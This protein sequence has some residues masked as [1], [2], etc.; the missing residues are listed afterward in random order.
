MEP[1]DNGHDTGL[2][3]EPL[4]RRQFL[5]NMLLAAASGSLLTG[6]VGTA[7]AAAKP[8]L[9]AAGGE[10]RKIKLGFLGCGRAAATGSPICGS[11]TADLKFGP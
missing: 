4:D 1:Q 9:P 6:A 3:Q 5:G 11:S 10:L 8:A 7:A 2:S